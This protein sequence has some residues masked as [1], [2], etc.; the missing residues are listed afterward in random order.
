MQRTLEF[1]QYRKLFREEHKNGA[2]YLHLKNPFMKKGERML[3][4]ASLPAM[5]HTPDV[6]DD[7]E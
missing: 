5:L 3:N 2:I 4:A 1:P 7:T 6:L